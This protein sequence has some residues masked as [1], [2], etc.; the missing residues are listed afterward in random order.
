MIQPEPE[1]IIACFDYSLP[2]RLHKFPN[3]LYSKLA[4][5][6]FTKL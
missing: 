6:W 3:K 4:N 5:L 1:F 2:A